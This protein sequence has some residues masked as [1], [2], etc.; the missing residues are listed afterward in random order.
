MTR[1][2]KHRMILALSE[3]MAVS[4]RGSILENWGIQSRQGG[5]NVV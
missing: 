5:H 4:Y 1:V 2:I 3:L